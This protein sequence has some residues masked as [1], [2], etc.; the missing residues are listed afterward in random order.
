LHTNVQVPAE[1]RAARPSARPG[2]GTVPA[3]S[4]GG[5]HTRLRPVRLAS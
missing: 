5:P 4:G 2:Y 3:G 1:R